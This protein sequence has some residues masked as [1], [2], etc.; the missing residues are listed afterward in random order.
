[1]FHQ[2]SFIHIKIQL[3]YTEIM[4]KYALNYQHAAVA[5]QLS[6]KATHK[7]F[8]TCGKHILISLKCHLSHSHWRLNYSKFYNSPLLRFTSFFFYCNYCLI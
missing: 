5:G 3:N 4:Q 2:L 6:E 8:L 1:M 7:C